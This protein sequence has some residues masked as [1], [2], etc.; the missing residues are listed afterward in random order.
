MEISKIITEKLVIKPSEKFQLTEEILTSDGV[1]KQ[2]TPQSV[3]CLRNE[4]P[5]KIFQHLK[6]DIDNIILKAIHKEPERRYD[7][8]EQF[9]EDIRRHIIGLPV[10]ARKDTA[11]YRFSKFVQRH[12]VGF[13]LS[14]LLLL[15][16]I[17]SAIVIS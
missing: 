16:I 12:K 5:D 10:I 15:L 2:I 13:A 14:S 9:S 1:T 11:S 3:S 4:K 17:A 8:V 7:S 6:G